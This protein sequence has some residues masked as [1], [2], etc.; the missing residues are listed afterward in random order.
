MKSAAEAAIGHSAFAPLHL[1]EA[2]PSKHPR[3]CMFGEVYNLPLKINRLQ[4]GLVRLN[5]IQPNSSSL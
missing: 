2:I 1:R 3:R 5:A 4:K